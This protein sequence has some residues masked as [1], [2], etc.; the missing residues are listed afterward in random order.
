ML[1]VRISRHILMQMRR[2]QQ[3]SMCSEWTVS[4]HS[5]ET[6]MSDLRM[7]SSDAS[8]VV[9]PIPFRNDCILYD[10][11]QVHD[12]GKLQLLLS[13]TDS[14]RSP[15]K[16]KLAVLLAIIIA[17]PVVVSFIVVVAVLIA[18][19]K[20]SLVPNPKRKR[21]AASVELGSKSSE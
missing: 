18:K 5:L 9:S 3:L 19:D 1:P 7:S 2:V 13:A 12:Q 16:S 17:V 10:A 6:Y 15:K 4:D 11:S 8:P 21:F 20:I 14:C